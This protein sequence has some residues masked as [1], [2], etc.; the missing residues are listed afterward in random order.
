MKK[1]QSKVTIY[2]STR[3][4]SNTG[5]EARITLKL[6]HK[7]IKLLKNLKKYIANIESVGFVDPS[8]VIDNSEFEA[9]Y[10]HKKLLPSKPI[11]A[12]QD[13]LDL[14][15]LIIVKLNN[16]VK[17]NKIS[18][19]NKKT[20]IKKG[21]VKISDDGFFCFTVTSNTG[22]GKFESF[23]NIDLDNLQAAYSHA[24]KVN[25]KHVV[26]DGGLNA[27]FTKR[28]PVLTNLDLLQMDNFKK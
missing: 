14:E 24:I 19:Y 28:K 15:K 1:K 10:A 16:I 6:D 11:K 23:K 21:N 26:I 18:N 13:R 27:Q 7:A 17:L 3:N 12:D 5:H 22:F 4:L 9:F 20:P 25:A 2:L 8:D